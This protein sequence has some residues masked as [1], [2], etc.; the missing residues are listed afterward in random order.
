[1][2]VGLQSVS[3]DSIGQTYNRL[4]VLKVFQKNNHAFCEVRCECGNIK[5]CS[6]A[7]VK[8]GIIKSCGCL[9]NQLCLERQNLK[10]NLKY[11]YNVDFFKTLTDN[12]AYVLGL[13]YTDGCLSKSSYTFSITLRTE[14]DSK[15]LEKIGMLLRNS[16]FVS[17][18]KNGNNTL[19][20]QYKEMYEDL[21]DWGLHPNK[22]RTISPDE[23]LK[24]NRHFWRGVIDGNG[25]IYFSRDKLHLG[26]CGTFSMVDNFKNWCA[27]YTSFRAKPLL[28]SNSDFLHKFTLMNQNAEKLLGILYENCELYLK[29]KQQFVNTKL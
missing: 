7:N 19:S 15:L 9:F 8:R 23:R 17:K 29:R 25:T 16:T 3:L 6:L 2:R 27:Q 28:Y 1:M 5:E 26:L 10:T 11:N 14:E 12:S 18:A 20:C 22:S 4:T 21:L 13:I 24:N